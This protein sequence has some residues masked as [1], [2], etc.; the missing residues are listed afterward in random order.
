MAFAPGS[1]P[2][3]HD[4]LTAIWPLLRRNRERVHA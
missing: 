1:Q 3:D 2:D 4:Q